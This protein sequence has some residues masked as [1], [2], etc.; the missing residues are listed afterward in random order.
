[1]HLQHWQQP[2]LPDGFFDYQAY[3]QRMCGSLQYVRKEEY[4][5]AL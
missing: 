3:S 2:E 5:R 1:M 4:K